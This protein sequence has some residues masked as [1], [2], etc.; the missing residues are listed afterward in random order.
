M[1]TIHEVL[2]DGPFRR[3]VHPEW[4]ERYPWLV[5]GTTAA[6][7]DLRLFGDLP[8]GGVLARWERLR[9]ALGATEVVHA[10]Q[11]H[12]ARVVRHAVVGAPG[13]RLAGRADGH[14]TSVPGILLTVSVADCVPVSIIDPRSRS[15]AL[16]HAG[17]RGLAAGI[18]RQGLEALQAAGSNP[19]DL[20]LHAGPSIC[21]DCY[22]VGPE[23]HRALGV[24]DPGKPEPLDLAA[25]VL[26]LATSAGVR[27]DRVTRSAHCTR[28]APER[29]YSHRAGASG[30]QVGY[31]GVRGSAAAP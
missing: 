16:L 28:C 29:F 12:E 24:A 13:M 3:Y 9:D 27:S 10:R 21:G 30:R 18:V 23:V 6:D 20:Y 22:E 2:E 1:R 15:V 14:V 8:S 26:E 4:R 11:V 17:W 31:L 7:G 19:G 5:Q 25:V